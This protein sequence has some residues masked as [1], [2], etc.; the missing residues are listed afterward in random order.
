VGFDIGQGFVFLGQVI[1]NPRK[2][3][4]LL[5]IGQI[6]CVEMMLVGK[7]AAALAALAP[8]I[9]I[10]SSAESQSPFACNLSKEQEFCR[11]AKAFA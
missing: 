9:K 7:H 1:Q 8:W 11:F 4:V 6:S 5:H 2:Q 10:V 3:S